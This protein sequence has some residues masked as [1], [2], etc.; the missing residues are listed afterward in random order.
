[1]V[2]VLQKVTFIQLESEVLR[3]TLILTFISCDSFVGLGRSV[4]FSF[5]YN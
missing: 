2:P 5:L 1:M 3:L 4:A